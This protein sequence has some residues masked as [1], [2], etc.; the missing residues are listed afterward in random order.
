V[1]RLEHE[2][3]STLADERLTVPVRPDASHLIQAGVR[4]RRRN[5]AI[6]TAA[7]AVVLLGGGVA[8]A[9]LVGDSGGDE[10]IV[11]PTGGGQPSGKP[12]RPAPTQ[13]ELAWDAVPYDYRHP[14]AF[15]GAIA[16]P[17]IPWCRAGE[18]SLSQS[19]Q[20]ATGSLMGTVAVANTSASTCALQ[21]QPAVSMQTADGHP[22]LTSRPEPFFVDAWIK[23]APGHTAAAAV[24]WFPEFCHVVPVGR[25]SVTLPH[26]GGS[27]STAMQGSPRC[28]IDTVVPQV[29][30]LD[31]GGFVP[32]QTDPFTP[33]AGL[34]ATLDK[35]PASVQAGSVLAYRLQLQS[36]DAP[37][38]TLDPCLPYRER[39]VD[40]T[41]GVVLYEQDFLLND[42][43]ASP[44]IAIHDPQ[45][46]QS[47]YFDLRYDVPLSAPPGD[48][49]LV[50]QSVLKPVNAVSDDVIHI[51]SGPA[52]CRDGQLRASAGATGAGLGS[53]YDVI[54]FRNISA[55]TCSLYGFPGVQLTDGDGRGVTTR[56]QRDSVMPHLVVLAPGA[57]A[58]ATISGA[59]SGPNGGATACKPFAGVLVIAPGQHRQTLVRG[60]GDRCYDTVSIWPVVAGT[61]GSLNSP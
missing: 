48:Y 37:S 27:L 24:T 14:P 13:T 18:L 10:R 31:V 46:N 47:T 41:T 16:D 21:G 17:S 40:H 56:Q 28:D 60:V 58:S 45:S 22:L 5:R 7:A 52:A 42:C 57:T 11:P 35:V 51:V 32:N 50:W 25:V 39:L 44:P 49:D 36:M 2:L 30:H 23:L 29:G 61:R 6:A 43:G 8:T 19:F 20:G 53:Y 33:L 3:R 15:A 1:D 34:Q 12:A 59:D 26:G 54:V 55:T 9:S 38:V 4:R